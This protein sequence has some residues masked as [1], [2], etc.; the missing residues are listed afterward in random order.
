MAIDINKLKKQFD[1]MKG[2]SDSFTP[3]EG[4]TR[5][6]IL[7]PWDR[8]SDM[9]LKKIAYHDIYGER[10]NCPKEINNE[11]C[12]ICAKVRQLYATKREEDAALAKQIRAIQ[13]FFFNIIVRGQESKGVQKFGCGK[14]L[15]EKIMNVVTVE[16]GKDIT[17]PVNGHDFVIV[18]TMNGD[19]PDYSS[20]YVVF[21]E[22]VLGNEEWLTKK[23]DM[24]RE[25]S[26]KSYDELRDIIEKRMGPTVTSQYA[27][28][29]ST[30]A[31]TRPQAVAQPRPVVQPQ[32]AQPQPVIQPQPAAQVIQPQPVQTTTVAA[33]APQVAPTTVQTAPATAM[34]PAGN[35]A[36]SADEILGMLNNQ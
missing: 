11:P 24:D 31:A 19:F 5:V 30:V 17:D 1:A 32:V 23:Y 16:L 9:F 34:A 29:G 20:S 7:P 2:N 22:S 4:E 18:K 21:Q 12:P 3:S 6:R 14:K 10:I 33:P 15:A 13:R 36:M 26:C 8:N 28:T 27:P 25:F 35:K